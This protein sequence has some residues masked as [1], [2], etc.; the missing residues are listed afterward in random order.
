MLFSV[1]PLCMMPFYIMLLS[2]N[3][4]LHDA[5]LGDTLL[6]G[7]HLMISLFTIFISLLL[8]FEDACPNQWFLVLVSRKT[9]MAEQNG[10]KT[11]T[12]S[13]SDKSQ[14]PDCQEFPVSLRN[15]R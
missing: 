1:V 15:Y 14:S 3:A 13:F 7:I 10:L 2:I 6:H 8:A 11:S 4:F 12:Q 5:F 9:N